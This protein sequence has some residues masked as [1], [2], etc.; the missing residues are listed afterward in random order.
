MKKSLYH[1]ENLTQVYRD[2]SVLDVDR[3]NIDVQTITGLI[4][5]NGSG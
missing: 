1:L 4:G 2:R 5:P 3:L